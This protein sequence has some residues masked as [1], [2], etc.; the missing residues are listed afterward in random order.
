MVLNSLATLPRR[1]ATALATFAAL[2]GTVA[3][4][5]GTPKAG[6]AFPNLADYSLEGTVPDLAGKV[7]IVDFWASWCGPCTESFPAFKEL[8]EKYGSQGLVI[9]AI[10]VDE[11]KGAMDMFLKKH[12]VP[13][14]VMR[15]AKQKLA[16]RLDLPT[17]PVTFILDRTGKIHQVHKS[18]EGDS[19]RKEFIAIVEKLLKP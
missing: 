7:V 18:Y 9:V 5:A 2:L 3:A 10:S 1:M 11:D 12:P 15:D 6:E 13:F 19:T 17:V 8:Q 16:E 14:A 4:L